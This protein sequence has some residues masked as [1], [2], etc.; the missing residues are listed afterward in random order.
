MKAFPN[1]V[2]PKTAMSQWLMD[3]LRYP[4]DLF[5]VQRELLTRYHVKDAQTFLS[6]S[7]VLA[8]PGRPDQQVGQRGAGRCC[9]SMRMPDQQ[10]QTFSLTT[11]FTPN[12]R[13]NLS[14]FMS[15]DSEAG[16]SDYGKIRIL[17]KL[18]TSGSPSTG[19]NRSRASST[20]NR[21]SPSRSG[22]RAG[23]RKSSTAIC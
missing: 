18:P 8:G 14:A 2:E 16:T 7:E 1:T 22:S 9:L 13:D 11:T 19:P 10:A 12:G 17:K 6:G 4:Q 23:T 20:P 15:V 3:H 5:K 21:T